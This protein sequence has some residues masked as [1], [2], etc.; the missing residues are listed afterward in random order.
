MV[1]VGEHYAFRRVMIR[2]HCEVIENAQV[3]KEVM[4][5]AGESAT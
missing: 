1:D 3:V 2:G 5:L 4:R